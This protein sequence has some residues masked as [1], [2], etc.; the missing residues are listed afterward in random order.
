[1]TY[2]ARRLR[3]PFLACLLLSAP[4]G[5]S[6]CASASVDA[7]EGTPRSWSQSIHDVNAKRTI[8]ARMLRAH[9]Y[10]LSK[11]DVDVAEG[12]VLLTGYVPTKE[13]RI[14]AAR[15]A[16]SALHVDQV[17]NEV[18]IKPKHGFIRNTKDSILESSV[19]T[20][21][22]VDKYVKRRNFNIET[23]DGVVYLMGVARDAQELDRAARIAA[24]TQGAREVVSYVRIANNGARTLP[25]D[26]M[27]APLPQQDRAERIAPMTRAPMNK[28][29]PRSRRNPGTTRSAQGDS[30]EGKVVIPND[31]TIAPYYVDPETGKQIPVRFSRE[32]P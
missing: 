15:I 27:S 29:I 7:R 32:K 19:E 10:D 2:R 23:H 18:Q 12:V 5:L 4:L 21:F 24:L 6:A 20:R 25:D 9:D 17:G 26:M 16:W 30:P 31:P 3:D 1:M 28:P 14:E 8:D 11:I 22:T 13:D